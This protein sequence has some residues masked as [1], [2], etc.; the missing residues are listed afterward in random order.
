MVN[1]KLTTIISLILTLLLATGCSTFTKGKDNPTVSAAFTATGTQGLVMNF[2]TDQP[3]AKVYTQGPLTFMVEVYNKGTYT[4]P[5]AAFYLTGFDP[6]ILVGL[7]SSYVMSQTLE[8]KSQFNPDGGYTT[9]SFSTSTVTLPT[10]MPNYKPTF[11]LT[12]CY[13]YQTISTGLVCVDPNPLDTTSDKA[14]KVQKTYA[15]GSQGAPVAITSV[16]SEARPTGMFFRIHVANTAGG[17]QQ[18]SGTVFDANKMSSC[19]A[20][21][22]Y[23]DLNV[24]TF[25]VDIASTALQCQPSNGELRLVNNKGTIF[26]QFTNTQNTLAYQTPLN[27]KLSYGYKSSVS[28]VVEIENLNFAR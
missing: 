18:A 13:P 24:M 6:N 15:T 16:E 20:G 1:N 7:Q 2:L 4:V 21:L 14:C 10:T 3:P 17:T 5:S 28:K 19:P 11:L 26:C 23:S 8:G 25:S 27:V 22:Q 12:A 9:M